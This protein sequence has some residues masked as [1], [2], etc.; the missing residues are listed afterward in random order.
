MVRG[1][2]RPG[3]PSSQVSPNVG[4]QGRPL[5]VVA[6]VVTK[7]AAP[8]EESP[9][10]LGEGRVLSRDEG[11]KGLAPAS[12]ISADWSN[13]AA[14]V[15]TSRGMKSSSRWASRVVVPFPFLRS[16]SPK[17]MRL[18][19]IESTCGKR[20]SL[21]QRWLAYSKR[22]SRKAAVAS[23]DAN[24]F[25]SSTGLPSSLLVWLRSSLP[26]PRSPWWPR[27]KR[28]RCRHCAF[29]AATATRCV[30]S[31][32]LQTKNPTAKELNGMTTLCSQ[33]SMLSMDSSDKMYLNQSSKYIQALVKT[34]N[35]AMPAMIASHSLRGRG[36]GWS[37]S[38]SIF[39]LLMF[40]AE[41]RADPPPPRKRC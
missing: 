29:H 14:A 41:D 25:V 12:P 10:P 26:L 19:Y 11:S 21:T 28:V 31:L 27:I 30:F 8:G 20:S 7:G 38:A 22:A 4:T 36:G 37:S 18:S 17:S 35:V 32:T 3:V 23:R 13:P 40:A 6:V 9:P 39:A 1:E 5:V 2:K 33:S 24:V 15:L 16:F 34:T